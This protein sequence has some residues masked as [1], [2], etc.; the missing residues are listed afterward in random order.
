MVHRT[1]RRPDVSDIFAGHGSD[2][3]R[4]A[5]LYDLEHDDL[6]E[7]VPFWRE[8][9]AR[10]PGRVLDVGSG[11][12][13]L[14]RPLIEGGASSVTAID[15]SSELL[16]RAGAR[17]AADAALSAAAADGRIDLV[18]GDIRALRSSVRRPP[19]GYTLVVCAGVL[20]H[21][22]GPEEAIRTLEDAAALLASDG[23]VVIDSLGPAQTPDR[24]LALSVDWERA[25]PAGRVVRRSE[26]VRR[27]L[28]D[29]LH[30]TYSTITDTVGPDGT[31]ARLPATFRL[32][33]PSYDGVD[34]MLEA[35]GLTAELLWGSY[36]LE[37]FDAVDSE[38]WI[39]VAR[40]R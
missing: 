22:S 28:P 20:P 23:R 27:E 25:T 17:I 12:G 11:S 14:L 4:L 9:A 32:W 26:I 35:A 16:A 40:R 7:D 36:E 10:H 33:Y 19:G 18:H 24:D 15:G 21:L 8:L 38:R 2:P 3:A 34:A 39:V 13:R 30:V 31:I 1:E 37:P 29:G 6:H 5:E